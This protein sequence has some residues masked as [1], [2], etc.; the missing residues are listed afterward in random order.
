M[1]L[2]RAVNTLSGILFF[3][4]GPFRKNLPYFKLR[5]LQEIDYKN[6]F[7][8]KNIPKFLFLKKKKKKKKKKLY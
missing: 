6:Q 2:R 3:C 1:R 8:N 7:I 4:R 5:D